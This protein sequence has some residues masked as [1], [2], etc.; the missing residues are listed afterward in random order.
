MLT[1]T[2][3]IATVAMVCWLC[4]KFPAEGGYTHCGP[5]GR[6][7]ADTAHRQAASAWRWSQ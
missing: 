7:I 2:K 4:N 5:C 6:K 1:R 3:T